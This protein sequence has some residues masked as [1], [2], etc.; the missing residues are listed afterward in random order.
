MVHGAVKSPLALSIGSVGLIVVGIIGLSYLRQSPGLD[1]LTNPPQASADLQTAELIKPTATDPWGRAMEYGWAAAVAAQS[2]QT[3]ADWKRVG[4]LWL[5]A[6][7]ELEQIPPNSPQAAQAQA[8]LQE[9]LKN[10]DKA[11]ERRATAPAENPTGSL[12]LSQGTM[13]SILENT[14]LAYTFGGSQGRVGK[15]A[16]G[17]AMVEFSGPADNLSQV[18]LAVKGQ[19]APPSMA[20][21][22]YANQFLAVVAPDWTVR[23]RW[24][25][26]S[27]KHLRNNPGKP[28]TSDYGPRQIRLSL[29]PD[30]STILITV[31][32]PGE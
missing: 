28:V 19:D 6:V 3:Q 11:E 27:F 4:D 8:K 13:Q 22:V 2:A 17:M 10:F 31:T 23:N 16:D 5:Q 26:S 15:S 7:A 18:R 1:G 32:G 24:L 21:M 25:S 30:K 9:Y 29:E 20:Q 14:P 12:K